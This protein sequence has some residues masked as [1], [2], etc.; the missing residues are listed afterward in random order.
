V[1]SCLL[2]L[3]LLLLLCCC[4]T[5]RRLQI[6]PS[7]VHLDCLPLDVTLTNPLPFLTRVSTHSN[8]VQKGKPSNSAL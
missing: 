4:F 6:V 7:R 1:D 5:R 8:A 3:L 2:L